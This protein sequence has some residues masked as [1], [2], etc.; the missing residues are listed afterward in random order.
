M[1]YSYSFKKDNN[2]WKYYKLLENI[3]KYENNIDS[4][5]IHYVS[6]CNIINKQYYKSKSKLIEILKSMIYIN[7]LVDYKK[8]VFYF[9]KNEIEIKMAKEINF[10]EYIFE[11]YNFNVNIDKRNIF[12][13]YLDNFEN[14]NIDN[15]K[16]KELLLNNYYY[17]WM[18]NIKDIKI[19]D[20]EFNKYN[21]FNKEYQIIKKYNFYENLLKWNKEQKLKVNEIKFNYDFKSKSPEFKNIKHEY[22]YYDFMFK[23]NSKKYVFIYQNL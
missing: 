11:V 19:I 13:K 5:W 17:T 9:E 10:K 22:I 12:E 6:F 14:D 8:Y 2:E 7:K 16:I 18:K 23:I 3:I 21:C 1:K 20:Y 4:I 15:S